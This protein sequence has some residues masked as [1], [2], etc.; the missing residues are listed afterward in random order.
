MGA[1]GGACETGRSMLSARGCAICFNMFCA[2]GPTICSNIVRDMF[3]QG[4]RRSLMGRAFFV[5]GFFGG[6][7]PVFAP[8]FAPF[9]GG[10]SSF[11]PF[12]SF[13]WFFRFGGLASPLCLTSAFA[14]APL[15]RLLTPWNS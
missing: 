6:V 5:F 4:V 15:K 7:A 8:F 2:S 3:Q 11:S 13:F 12:S 9:F 1:D 14:A 10:A